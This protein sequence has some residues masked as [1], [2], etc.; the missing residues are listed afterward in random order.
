[1]YAEIANLPEDKDVKEDAAKAM[2]NETGLPTEAVNG[3][4]WSGNETLAQLLWYLN[5]SSYWCNPYVHLCARSRNNL[6]TSAQP[7][8]H[9]AL[10]YKYVDS[11]SRRT[12]MPLS[13]M[14]GLENTPQD[15]NAPP[16]NGMTQPEHAVYQY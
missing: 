14:H 11:T 6:M 13:A 10:Y 15:L 12:G 7:I 5:V 1:M 2:E 3:N 16:M 9:R 4:G 8:E